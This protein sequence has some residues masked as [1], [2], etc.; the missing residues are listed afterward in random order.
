MNTWGLSTLGRL[1]MRLWR[2]FH[3]WRAKRMYARVMRMEPESERLLNKADRLMRKHAED[4][5]QRFP[6][7]GEDD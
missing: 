5:Q 1:P 6:F 4:P 7:G 3:I 2:R